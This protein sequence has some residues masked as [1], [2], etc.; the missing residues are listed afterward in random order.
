MYSELFINGKRQSLA[1]FPNNGYIKTDKVVEIGKNS[2]N[3]ANGDPS[4]DTY[5][6]NESLAS[7]ILGWQNIDDV[8]MYGFW[9]YDWADG[10]TPIESFN[11]ESNLLTTKYQSF[12]GIKEN[13]PYFF[14]N[15]LEELDTE[16][17]WYLDRSNG[18]LCIYEPSNFKDS[19]INLSI[20][21]DTAISITAN[22]I[23]LRNLT[24]QGTRGNGIEIIGN[25]NA[26]EN[27]IITN[28]GGQAINTIGLN[29]TITKN[30]K[31]I[32]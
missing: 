10:S 14:Y 15:C 23:T 30:G 20:S 24:I 12:F 9:Q 18:L 6:L 17:E 2:K 7:K 28:I 4:G 26:I 13:A 22:Y 11:S 21:I 3:K 31:S 32:E 27:C 29:N 19:I 16:G 25:N 5:K 8:W 1:R